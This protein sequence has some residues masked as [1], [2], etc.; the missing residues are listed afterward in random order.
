MRQLFDSAGR[1]LHGNVAMF[2]RE[3]AEL[4]QAVVRGD[5]VAGSGADGSGSGVGADRGCDSRA[6]SPEVGRSLIGV[7][8]GRGDRRDPFDRATTAEGATALG[9]RLA[10]CD[11]G[12]MAVARHGSF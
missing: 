7:G 1:G 4:E 2:T 8:A 11:A 12:P 9:L 10:G 3:P 5:G 6:S